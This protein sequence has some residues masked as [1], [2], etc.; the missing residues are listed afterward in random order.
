M[1]GVIAAVAVDVVIYYS[2]TIAGN[3]APPPSKYFIGPISGACLVFAI[4]WGVSLRV[5]RDQMLLPREP[6]DPTSPAPDQPRNNPTIFVKIIGCL[7]GCLFFFLAGMG[8]YQGHMT[9]GKH[10]HHEIYASRDPVLFWLNVTFYVALGAYLIYR[11]F[12]RPNR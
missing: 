7:L 1:W 9:V 4:F 11:T 6:S 10:S 12:K 3:P 2:T 8:I 5:N